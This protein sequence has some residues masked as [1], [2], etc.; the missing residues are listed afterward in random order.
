MRL[1]GV[2]DSGLVPVL[3]VGGAA[4]FLTTNLTGLRPEWREMDRPDGRRAPERRPEEDAKPA[5]TRPGA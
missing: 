2:R 3:F 5:G 1:P 4:Y